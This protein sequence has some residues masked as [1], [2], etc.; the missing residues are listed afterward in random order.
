[1]TIKN[2]RKRSRKRTYHTWWY[3]EVE[4]EAWRQ[5]Q[6]ETELKLMYGQQQLEQ[7]QITLSGLISKINI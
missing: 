5:F 4:I 3:S 6:V 1:M 2:K 7:G